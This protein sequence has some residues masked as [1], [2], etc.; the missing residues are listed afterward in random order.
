MLSAEPRLS[1]ALAPHLM[2]I[3]ILFR[4]GAKQNPFRRVVLA[5]LKT[6]GA[7]EIIICS[8]FYQESFRSSAYKV[9]AGGLAAR[10]KKS[11]ARVITIGVHNAA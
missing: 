8:G 6:P 10:L 4:R 7:E 3:A 5:A 1:M 2:S 11:R 9:T